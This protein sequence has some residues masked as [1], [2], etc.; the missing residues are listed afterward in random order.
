MS[1]RIASCFWA[2]I[3]VAPAADPRW[4]DDAPVPPKSTHQCP[5]AAGRYC[6]GKQENGKTAEE[7][8]KTGKLQRKTGAGGQLPHSFG[9]FEFG[10]VSCRLK[11]RKGKDAP[12]SEILSTVASARSSPEYLYSSLWEPS[13][14]KRSLS[15][16]IYT[17]DGSSKISILKDLF[18]YRWQLQNQGGGGPT[19]SVRLI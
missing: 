12:S 18:Q 6:R 4:L 15:S 17:I 13:A 2:M 14:T 3:H 19:V 5:M 7:N 11:N 1:S 9:P 16:D 10:D 8:R